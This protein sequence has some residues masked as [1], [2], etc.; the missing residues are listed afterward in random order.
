MLKSTK[1][2]KELNL[3]SLANAVNQEHKMRLKATLARTLPKL[4][5][6]K[7]EEFS[8]NP[9]TIFDGIAAVF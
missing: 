1:N 4:T 8:A 2:A 7:I 5:K 9:L 6:T 3:W